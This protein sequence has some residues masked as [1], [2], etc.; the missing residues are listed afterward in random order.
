MVSSKSDMSVE[1]ERPSEVLKVSKSLGIVFGFAIVSK[2][3]GEPYFDTQGDHI[4]EDA[5]LKASADFMESSRAAKEMHAG[6]DIGDVL[7][8]FPLTSDIAE[9]LDIT[10][11]RTGLLIGMRPGPEALAKFEDGTYTGFSIGGRYVQ[12]ERAE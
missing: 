2:V 8:A 1:F 7:Y 5:M 4:P 3:D 10:T 12:N 11:K 6:D 9:A